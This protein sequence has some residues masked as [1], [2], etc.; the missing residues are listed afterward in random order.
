MI[1]FGMATTDD[2]ITNIINLC[3][4]WNKLMGHDLTF[5]VMF[6]DLRR[7]VDVGDVVFYAAED[8]KIIGF[9]CGSISKQLFSTIKCTIEFLY[10]VIPK[11]RGKGVADKLRD[12]L[13]EWAKLNECKVLIVG[14]SVSGSD[15]PKRVADGLEK[16]G[17]YLY[18][19]QM[20][21]DL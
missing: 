3:V 6:K 19:Y 12:I 5:D 10:Y 8:N 13:Q 21:K 11:Y 7:A 14:A 9:I 1:T 18:G 17:F 16:K 15:N 4:E 20:R 2:E